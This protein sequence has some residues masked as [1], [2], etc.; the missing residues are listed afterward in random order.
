[1][2]AHGTMI[3]MASIWSMI[4]LEHARVYEAHGPWHMACGTS[5]DS[6]GNTDVSYACPMMVVWM[7][8]M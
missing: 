3:R 8:V 2:A 4:S 7:W 6:H 1:M 5:I